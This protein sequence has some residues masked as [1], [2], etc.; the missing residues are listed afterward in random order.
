MMTLSCF[1]HKMQF[2]CVKME[3]QKIANFLNTTPD[4]K[5]QKQDLLLKSVL[6]FMIK[7]KKIITVLINRL[8]PKHQ[9]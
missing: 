4:H 5:E 8:E 9:C 1:E 7:Q 3:F 6:K 2:Y